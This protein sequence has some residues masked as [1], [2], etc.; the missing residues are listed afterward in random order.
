MVSK[1]P[2]LKL[3]VDYFVAGCVLHF[4]GR[5]HVTEVVMMEIVMGRQYHES[6][7][8]HLTGANGEEQNLRQKGEVHRTVWPEMARRLCVSSGGSTKDW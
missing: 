2:L 3:V 8:G 4:C 1:D 7:N 6:M 5:G